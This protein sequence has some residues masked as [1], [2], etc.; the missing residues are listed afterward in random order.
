MP[1]L[2]YKNSRSCLD[3]IMGFTLIEL[4][5]VVAIFTIIFA[6]ALPIYSN[7]MIRMKVGE[8]FSIAAAAKTAATD[9]CQS[10]PGIAVLTNDLAD[11]L[12][13][14]SK[15]VEMLDISGS[16]TR[17]VI[18]ITTQNT[19]S[20]TSPVLILTGEPDSNGNQ[21]SWTCTTMNE[22]NMLVP[23]SCRN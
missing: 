16:C 7:Y 14:A 15:Y 5:I 12:F 23:E 8:A 2:L 17:P 1:N 21:F 10:E 20:T 18:T 3:P 22:Q 13:K 6:L 19:G 4:M 11:Y 9:T